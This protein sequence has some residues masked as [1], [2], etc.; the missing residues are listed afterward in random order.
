MEEKEGRKKERRKKEKG[1]RGF[2]LPGS[3]T[4]SVGVTPS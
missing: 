3:H 2:N 4:R 1:R